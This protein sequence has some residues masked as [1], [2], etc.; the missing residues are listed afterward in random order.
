VRPLQ[1]AEFSKCRRRRRCRVGARAPRQKG[2]DGP[3]YEQRANEL[4][5]RCRAQEIRAQ[6]RSCRPRGSARA[7]P[8]G[9]CVTVTA[10]QPAAPSSS[11]RR[12]TYCLPARAARY[13]Y[14]PSSAATRCTLLRQSRVLRH[15]P[16]SLAR[17]ASGA[18]AHHKSISTSSH[19][20]Q[21]S[22]PMQR[23]VVAALQLC[24]PRHLLPRTSG[25][26]SLR[27]S[28]ACAEY[29]LNSRLQ[30][31]TAVQHL[32]QSSAPV[33]AVL[34]VHDGH[35][36][37][38]SATRGS[39]HRTL[40]SEW[41][42]R[43]RWRLAKSVVPN[44]PKRCQVY[45]LTRAGASRGAC[46]LKRPSLHMTTSKTSGLVSKWRLMRPSKSGRL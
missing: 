10:P 6:A 15:H 34:T 22:A 3:E 32:P 21:L 1:H 30:A 2:K 17:Y 37:R 4:Q 35:R 7:S 33:Q 16:T 29:M 5:P 12:Y 36:H 42:R 39:A 46:L 40:T 13:T 20:S 27:K 45:S 9:G 25:H 31:Q 28:I 26:A 8:T 41:R 18:I 23:H 19:T 11:R 43:L 38:L 24:S 14:R 44:V